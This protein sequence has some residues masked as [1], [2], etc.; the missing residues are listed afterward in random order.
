MSGGP[1]GID[2]PRTKQ[3]CA[4]LTDR[5]VLNSVNASAAR[6]LR[7]GDALHL[8]A[9]SLRGPL[10]AI[11]AAGEEV[12]SITSAALAQLLACIEE[13]FR[14]VAE[15]QSVAGGRIEVLVRPE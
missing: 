3:D 14:F 4:S 8:Q 12:G 11:N 10:V 9:R 5:T 7:S 6:G 1:S 15:V 2:R 13:G